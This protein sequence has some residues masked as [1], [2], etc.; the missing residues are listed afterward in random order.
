MGDSAASWKGLAERKKQSILDSIPTQWRLP[1]EVPTAEQQKDITGSYIQQFLSEREIQITETD[2]VGIAK[3]TASGQWSAVEVTE[4]F[5]HRASLVHQLVS[6]SSFSES[7]YF[8]S[9]LRPAEQPTLMS[10]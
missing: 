2:V 5:C 4:A 10:Q 3:E 9:E 6:L 8:F 1:V 7:L